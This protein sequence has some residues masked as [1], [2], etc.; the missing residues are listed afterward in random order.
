MES[1]FN[2]NAVDNL[3]LL[4]TPHSLLQRP[5]QVLLLILKDNSDDDDF[6]M[7]D[8]ILSPQDEELL[9]RVESTPQSFPV[10]KASNGGGFNEAH[11]G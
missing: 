10:G 6:S 8:M 3:A 9:M 1:L 11:E 7:Y 2:I 5:M 4:P